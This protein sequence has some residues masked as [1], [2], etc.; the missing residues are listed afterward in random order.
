MVEYFLLCKDARPPTIQEITA[1]MK[2]AGWSLV[3]IR[4]WLGSEPF[5]VVNVGDLVD[6]D[7]TV[8]WP[9]DHPSAVEFEAALRSGDRTKLEGWI[10]DA[11]LSSAMWSS[12]SPFIVEEHS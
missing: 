3:V 5:H 7:T 4:N 1:T 12:E 9:Q 10:D 6:N 11:K 8:G 2:D